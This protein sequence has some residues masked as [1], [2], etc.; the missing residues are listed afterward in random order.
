MGLPQ[1]ADIPRAMRIPLQLSIPLI[2]AGLVLPIAHW[3]L[4]HLP[5]RATNCGSSVG[6]A[7]AADEAILRNAIDAYR[8][9]HADTFPA[10]DTF[11]QQLTLYTDAAGNTS[12]TSDT[13][14]TLGPYLRSVPL[15]PLGAN[16]N[17]STI[18][19]NEARGVAW[20]YDEHTGD[21]R[22]NCDRSLIR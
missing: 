7:L 12:P 16:R 10:L 5:R 1:T 6:A 8:Q 3:Q 15:M 21:I 14:H 22:G 19:S 18:S 20:I 2:A 11:A 13:T 9:D 17:L 4:W